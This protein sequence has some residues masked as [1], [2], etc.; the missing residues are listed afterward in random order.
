MVLKSVYF[1]PDI[2][3]RAKR[4]SGMVPL[5]AIIRKLVRLWLEGKINLDEYDD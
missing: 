5:A 2:W 4:Q 3:E 1:E